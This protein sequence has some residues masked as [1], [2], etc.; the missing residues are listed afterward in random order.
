[1]PASRSRIFCV[2]IAVFI[3][4]ALLAFCPA[5]VEAAATDLHALVRVPGGT[6]TDDASF[7]AAMGGCVL[8]HENHD[9]ELTRD[10]ILEA[11]LVIHGGEYTFDGA[12]CRIIRGFEDGHLI[13]AEAKA[14]LTLGD[15]RKDGEDVSLQISGGVKSEFGED[16]VLHLSL[17]E[18][19]AGIV[20]ENVS[21][22][23][24][25][26][27]EESEVVM[28]L[29]TE[30]MDNHSKVDG[31]G[32][33]CD[34]G[35]FTMVN[36][37]LTGCSS[38][39]NGGNVLAR[40]EGV[41]A[42]GSGLVS[43]GYAAEC[44]GNIAIEEKAEVLLSTGVL[45]NGRADLGGGIYA[46]GTVVIQSAEISNNTANKGGGIYYAADNTLAGGTF[47][48]NRA[49]CGGAIFNH[50]GSLVIKVGGAELNTA[51]RGGGI[52]N[53]GGMEIEDYIISKSTAEDCG[54]G[55]YNAQ[56]A[57]MTI[58]RGTV[59]NND[60]PRG[61]G[62]FN[63]GDC[64]I[65][66]CSIAVNSGDMG[67]GIMNEGSLQIYNGFYCSSGNETFLVLGEN[68]QGSLTLMEPITAVK[69]PLLVPGIKTED[70][71]Y[72]ADYKTTAALLSGDGE[73]VR[74][75]AKK[76]EVAANDSRFYGLTEDGRLK[77]KMNWI[78]PTVL[79][80]I[81]VLGITVGVILLVRRRKV[82]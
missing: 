3:L 69:Y 34:N 72:A 61:G 71:G 45:Q 77:V 41:F 74:D 35:S 68:G 76:F 18:K 2:M 19:D 22:A 50:A 75:A 53:E 24:I 26:V 17:S 48:E 49:V 40:N 57:T 15:D 28:H 82:R 46:A 58:H 6:V 63:A 52:Y 65:R 12:G 33:L 1:M 20:P 10:V 7:S 51:V 32:I 56:G 29:G 81:G 9:I 73:A 37:S 79:G 62:L 39:K 13:V 30:L 60:A 23:L 59:G 11:P 21:G 36:G 38:L 25:C 66:G 31:A 67:A 43:S 78:L 70:G 64:V 55:I 14:K 27:K 16:G 42:M 8:I 4:I 5:S 54:G 44:G 80:G 47:A